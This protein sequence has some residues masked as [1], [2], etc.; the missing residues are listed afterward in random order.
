MP[1]E[2]PTDL[3][4]LPGAVHYDGPVGGWGSAEGI[5]AVETIALAGP[6]AL[7]TLARQNKPGGFMC[8]SCAWAKPPN[9]HVAEFCENGAKATI[10]DLTSKRCR[11]AFFAQ[12][13]VAE[14]SQWSEFDLERRGV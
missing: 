7:D 14:L 5:L 13:T 6:G 9:P 4:P 10:W 2:E 8:V 12:H 11:P 1:S 3:S